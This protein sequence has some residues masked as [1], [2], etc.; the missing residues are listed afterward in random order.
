MP[1]SKETKIKTKNPAKK[2]LSL[3]SA[4]LIVIGS[5]IGAGIFLKNDEI[6]KNTQGNIWMACIAWVI[7]IFA[8]ICLAL[9]LTEL[10]SASNANKLGII[11]WIKIF[12]NDYL[13]QAGKKFMA[14]L[15][16]PINFFIMPYYAIMTLQEAFPNSAFAGLEWYYVALLALAITTWFIW[17]SGMSSKMTNIQNWVITS[18][19]FFPLVFAIVIGYIVVGINGEITPLVPEPTKTPL[20]NQLNPVSGLFVSIPSIFFVFDGF[21]STAGLQTEMKEPR[22][23]SIAMIIGLCVVSFIDI[24]ISVSLMISGKGSLAGLTDWF[25]ERNVLWILQ[26]FQI[27]VAFGIFGII[28]GFCLYSSNYYEDLIANKDIVFSKKLVNKMKPNS[29]LIGCGY[30]YILFCL[31]FIVATLIGSLGYID[32]ND[33]SDPTTGVGYTAHLS[34]LYSFVDLMANWTSVL[35][36][37]CIVVAIIGAIRN[38]KTK[39]VKTVNDK[40]FKWA[41]WVTILIVGISL[42]LIVI[43][44]FANLGLVSYYFSN[45][46]YDTQEDAIISLVAVI[47]TVVV[48]LGF[49]LIMFIPTKDRGRKHVNKKC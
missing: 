29:H 34:C 23:T 2:K 33:Y 13:Y 43:Q 41:S 42:L 3:I 7:A 25:K 28:N 39:K 6:L 8:I 20:F 27:F 44:T 4:I 19:K 32:T 24:L 21:Y 49:I 22:K 10:C 15:Y 1:L 12:C 38:I 5:S 17:T 14:Y 26:M 35:A 46:M 36:F 11:G 37:A 30:S 47:M 9:C 48:L 18:I 16:L 45:N 40:N 31:I